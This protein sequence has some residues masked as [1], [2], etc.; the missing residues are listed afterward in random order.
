M[1]ENHPQEELLI[2]YADGH[3]T[4]EEERQVRE[5]LKEDPTA[6]EFMQQL[7]LTHSWL[8]DASSTELDE[9]PTELSDFVNSYKHSIP[10]PAATPAAA[11]A[12]TQPNNGLNRLAIAASLVLGLI[13]GTLIGTSFQSSKTDTVL[14]KAE[15]SP[16]EWVRLVADYHRL[17][18]RE[19]I[20]NSST[21]KSAEVSTTLS[22]KLGRSTAVPD[23][24]SLSMEFK[25]QQSLTYND[26]TIFQL[27]YLP[28]VDKPVAVCILDAK[29]MAES[30]VISGTHAQI[31][32]AYWQDQEHAVVIVGELPDQQMQSIVN[33]VRDSL[34]S[35]S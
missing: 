12:T 24:T 15:A 27:V 1:I 17:Y 3:C 20:S 21:I 14:S 16:P 31:H 8:R 30:K 13:G 10:A 19:T 26:K 11:A 5:L 9:A 25:R 35:T 2:R 28:E 32:Y 29:D 23:L 7:E 18:A 22:D 4:P 34:F 6:Q 33:T